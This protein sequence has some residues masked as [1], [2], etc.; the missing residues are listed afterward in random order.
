MSEEEKNFCAPYTKLINA[1]LD[2]HAVEVSA[3][4]LSEVSGFADVFIVAV[5]RSELNAK[6]LKDTTKDALDEMGIGYRVEGET[7]TRW[8]LIDAGDLIV[9]ILSR[10]GRDFYRLDSLWG[11][12][13]T[14]K[15]K[16]KDE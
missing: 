11:D 3:H 5:A 15:F 1:L 7:S 16:D 13:P 8:T 9:N 10:E 14:E 6:T 2:K 12:A 4:D